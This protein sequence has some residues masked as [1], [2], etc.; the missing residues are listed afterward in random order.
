MTKVGRRASMLAIL[1]TL[2]LVLTS[3]TTF[4]KGKPTTEATN[5]LSVPA[6]LVGSTNPFGLTCP[7]DAPSVLVTPTGTPSTGYDVPG[8]YYVQ[9]LN[10]WRAQ[11]LA[12]ATGQTATAAWGDNLTGAPL[13]AG[14]PI[15]VEISLDNDTTLTMQGYDV[16]KLQNLL[17][18]ESAYGTLATGS[19]ETGFT[20]TPSTF[21]L[22]KTV[23][24]EDGTPT[25]VTINIRVF[26]SLATF[27]IQNLATGSYVVSPG[28][29][30]TAEINSTGAIVYGYNWGSG[31][32]KAATAVA[33]TYRI[34]FTFPQIQLTGTD[35]GTQ[36]GLNEV[37]LDVTVAASSGG[38]RHGG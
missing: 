34:T 2:A 22:T 25:T 13:K 30:A 26:D 17:D 24:G 31:K 18:R 36:V 14:T 5:N 33:G 38:G 28:T 8:Y 1:T 20:A 19:T 16:I 3:A 21:P 27:S 37:Y 12:G 9:G 10:T 7:S 32:G 4:A 6:I 15:R 35:A 11:C 29:A 23:I